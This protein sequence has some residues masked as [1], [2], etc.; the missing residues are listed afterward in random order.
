[1]QNRPVS[2]DWHRND[3]TT[4]GRHFQSL[5]VVLE[6]EQAI[7]KIVP[8]CPAALIQGGQHCSGMRLRQAA[9]CRSVKSVS[10]RALLMTDDD[11]SDSPD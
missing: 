4:G 3:P 5:P 11:P 9:L 10:G 2:L 8:K 1:M 7:S 6:S